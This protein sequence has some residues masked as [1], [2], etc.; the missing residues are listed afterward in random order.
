MDKPIISII[1]PVYNRETLIPRLADSIIPQ[2]S[3]EVEMVLV[4]DGS[5]DH[6]KCFAKCRKAR[7]LYRL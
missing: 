7:R 1:V 5:T 3:E 2:L 6:C 4:D